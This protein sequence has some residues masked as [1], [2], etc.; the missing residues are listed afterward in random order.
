MKI[1][2]IEIKW[3]GHSSFLIQ[4]EKKIYI[5]PY[6][7]QGGE[8]DI[9]LISHPHYDHCSLADINKIVKQGTVIVCPADCQ[10]KITKLDKEVEL[11]V[12]EAGQTI[13]LDRGIKI[14]AVPAYN[15]DKGFHPKSESW[16]GYIL[17]MGNVIVYYAGDTDLI[18]EMEKL[19]GYSSQ[20]EFVA[21]LPIGGKFTM[22]AE[23]AAEAASLIKPSLVL[24]MHYGNIIGSI[25][26][27]QKFVKLCQ[28]RE[29]KAEILEKE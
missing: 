20:G 17:K 23:E 3:L 11:Q 19:S 15:T 5:D 26:D 16:L 10:S 25:E 22:N 6:N 28:E 2:N 1:Q 24:P 9:V 27:A 14:G 18:P 29:I 7:I 8:A 4:N 12:I 13:E 21:L